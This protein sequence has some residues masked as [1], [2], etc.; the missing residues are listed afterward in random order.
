MEQDTAYPGWAPNPGSEVMRLAQ[1]VLT[2]VTGREA[3]VRALCPPPGHLTVH[4][5]K[6]HNPVLK[7][8]MWR[9]L[10]LPI[11]PTALFIL[12]AFVLHCCVRSMLQPCDR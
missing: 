5:C 2:E 10:T 4:H 12:R 9:V 6:P 3:K 7:L 1:E 8:L 11:G